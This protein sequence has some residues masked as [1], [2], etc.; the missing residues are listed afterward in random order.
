MRTSKRVVGTVTVTNDFNAWKT[1]GLNL[2][3][4]D[5]QLVATEGYRSSGPASITVQ[6]GWLKPDTG[7]R[8]CVQGCQGLSL[9]KKTCLTELESGTS[10]CILA[11]IYSVLEPALSFDVVKSSDTALVFCVYIRY[12]RKSFPMSFRNRVL[13][14]NFGEP[15]CVNS[16][17]KANRNWPCRWMGD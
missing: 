16:D 3:S 11:T 13:P 6:S 5:Y 2:G 4:R 8:D 10:Y 14:S 12:R 1:K 15:G 17:S 7:D 9:G